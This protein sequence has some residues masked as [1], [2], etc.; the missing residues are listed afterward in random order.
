[1]RL[2]FLSAV[3]AGMTLFSCNNTGS[4]GSSQPETRKDSISYALGQD[5]ASNLQQQ[6]IDIN[7]EA[8]LGGMQATMGE[9]GEAQLSEQDARMML[10]VL[11]QEVRRKQMEQMQNNPQAQ[12]GDQTNVTVGETA[13]EI[14]LPTPEGNELS[15][16]DLRGKVVLIDFW[17]SWCKPC[18]A[19]NPNVVRVYNQYKDQGFEILG[20]SLDRSK[21]AWVQAIQQDNLTWK[22]VSDLQF[23]NSEAAQVYGVSSIPYT[24]LVDQEG[25]VIAERLRGGG[26]EAKLAEVFGK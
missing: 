14:T 23:W 21:E 26:L 7:P 3:I 25:N 24:V 19:E 5:L 16:S 15:L 2:I 11:Q 9:D 18:R 22:H 10:M 6:G 4:L 12:P 13:P 1:M 17:A 20:V 8:L